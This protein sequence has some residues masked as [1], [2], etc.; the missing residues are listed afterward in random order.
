M[1]RILLH[2][3]QTS[4]QAVILLT[5]N[6]FFSLKFQTNWAYR[7]HGLGNQKLLEQNSNSFSTI[8]HSNLLT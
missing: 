6:P 7:G 2:R 1:K 8:Q 4:M 3:L 5:T